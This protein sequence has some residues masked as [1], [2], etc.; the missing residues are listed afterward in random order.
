[1]AV[2]AAVVLAAVATFAVLHRGQLPMCSAPQEKL[3]GVWDAGRKQALEAAFRRANV[4]F[5]E[6]ALRSVEQSLDRYTQKW[7]AAHGDACREGERGAEAIF[8]TRMTC[9]SQRLEELKAQTQ[10]LSTADATV[11]EN[12]AR[13]AQALG[14]VESCTRSGGRPWVSLLP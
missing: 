1:I 9:L 2:V 7:L 12:A 3:V 8:Y 5:A 14:T 4:P 13:M 10:V 11:V 6:D